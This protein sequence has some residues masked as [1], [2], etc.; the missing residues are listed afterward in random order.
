MQPDLVAYVPSNTIAPIIEYLH[1]R[2][3]RVLVIAREEE[4]VGIAGAAAL[5]GRLGAIVMQDNGFGNAL[6]ALATFP[7]AYHLPLLIVANTRGGLG[8]YNSMI[9]S[10]SEGVPAM[11]HAINVPVFTLDR[12]HPVSDWEHTVHE[13]GTHAVMTHRPVVVLM[14]FWGNGSG[15]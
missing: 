7:V 12:T 11:L 15:T 1:D 13:A 10:F 6:T 5:T 14:D 2:V 3:A 9:H 8:E 4:A